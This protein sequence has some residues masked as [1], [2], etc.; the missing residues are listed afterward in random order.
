MALPVAGMFGK[1]LIKEDPSPVCQMKV[2][3]KF[4]FNRGNIAKLLN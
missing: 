1:I 2:V 3:K 4:F